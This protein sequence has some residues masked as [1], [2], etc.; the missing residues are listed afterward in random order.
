MK[1]AILKSGKF[2]PDTSF[3]LPPL[4]QVSREPGERLA[5]EPGNL[6]QLILF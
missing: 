6:E 5:E 2:L 3:Q 1:M 4:I